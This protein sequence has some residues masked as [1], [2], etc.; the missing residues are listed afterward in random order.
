MKIIK[1]LNQYNYIINSGSVHGVSEND[2][3][4]VYLE[5]EEIIDPDTGKSLGKLE[6]PKERCVV[7]NIQDYFT[8]IRSKAMPK[9]VLSGSVA[10][11]MKALMGEL[12]QTDESFE[13]IKS[14]DKKVKVNDLVRKLSK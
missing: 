9:N 12:Y 7:Y 4:I 3:F 13:L 14:D 11:S 5:G 10:Y 1:V 8:T 6:I 2:E